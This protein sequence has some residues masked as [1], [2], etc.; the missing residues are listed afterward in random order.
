MGILIYIFVIGLTI[1]SFLNVC[2]YRI[3]K[4]ESISYPPS[5]C[6]A[7]GSRLK[8]LDLVPVLSYIFLK[9]RCRYCGEKISAQYPVIELTNA[10]LFLLL[11]EKFGLTVTFAANCFL[12]SLLLVIA[13]IDFKSQDI[14][15]NTIVTGI[16]GGA[17]F[18]TYCLLHDLPV[19]DKV[20][21]A[22]L[23]Y[24]IIAVIILVSKGG[25]GWGDA[26]IALLCGLFAGI[27]LTI[28]TLFLSF[29]IGAA[30]GILLILVKKKKRTDAIP[31]GPYIAIAS[32]ISLLIGNQV[33]AWYLNK[34]FLS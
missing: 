34:F 27:K 7:C 9:G 20:M 30:A 28:L 10:V 29:I 8:T 5:H 2:I 31:F 25:M 13:V 6:G 16:I 17:I 1:G 19:L 21:G 18:L 22:G 11:Y 33:I 3:P 32:V 23:G 14:Y 15:F 12:V 4:E 24:G 26:E